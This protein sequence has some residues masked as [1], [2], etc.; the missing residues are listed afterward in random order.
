MKRRGARWGVWEGAATGLLFCL[1][2]LF[3]VIGYLRGGEPA[4]SSLDRAL[5]LCAL[6]GG[7]LL[8]LLA[9]GLDDLRAFLVTGLVDAC[10]WLFASWVSAKV[11]GHALIEA[12]SEVY[13]FTMIGVLVAN[14]NLLPVILILEARRS[15]EPVRGAVRR[16]AF[17]MFGAVAAVDLTPLVGSVVPESSRK[18]VMLGWLGAALAAGGVLLYSAGRA[19]ARSTKRPRGTEP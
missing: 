10:A 9:R 19:A 14:L 15:P 1:P 16:R 5:I 11:M 7:A 6:G 17:G 12:I 2:A 4:L 13:W 18:L 8:A 3:L